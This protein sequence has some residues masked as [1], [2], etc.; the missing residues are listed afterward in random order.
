MKGNQGAS[1]L[2]KPTAGAGVSAIG[3]LVIGDM[4][5]LGQLLPVRRRLGQHDGAFE[6]TASY[7]QWENS[8]DTR[9]FG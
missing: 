2:Q 4:Q 8:A 3:H 9:S 5:Q 1:I 6:L 7:W